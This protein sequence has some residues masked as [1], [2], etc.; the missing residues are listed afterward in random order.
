MANYTATLPNTSTENVEAEVADT[1]A[2]KRFTYVGQEANLF[3]PKGTSPTA[4]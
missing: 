3:F 4:P 1:W 2:F